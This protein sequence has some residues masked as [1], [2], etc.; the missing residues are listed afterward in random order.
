MASRLDRIKDWSDLARKAEYDPGQLAAI[1]SVSLRQLQR[2]TKE[3]FQLT[4]QTWLNTLRLSEAK[5]LLRDGMSAKS[6]AITLGY[7]QL[8]HFSRE[9]KRHAG[10]PPTAFAMEEII[11]SVNTLQPPDNRQCRL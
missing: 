10:L 6:T 7:K 3:N 8:S 11:Q 5:R 2:F 4:P 9:F 1:C